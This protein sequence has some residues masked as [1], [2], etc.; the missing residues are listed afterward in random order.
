M[1]Q[2]HHMGVGALQT[3]MGQALMNVTMGAAQEM[4]PGMWVWQLSQQAAAQHICL[5]LQVP[6][7]WI[8][9]LVGAQLCLH[10]Q[11]QTKQL[12]QQQE[13]GHEHIWDQ[14]QVQEAQQQQ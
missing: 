1:A 13:H 12:Q 4:A 11:Q 6:L 3:G 5:Q 8:A 7:A 2:A 9:V 14:Q 10:Q